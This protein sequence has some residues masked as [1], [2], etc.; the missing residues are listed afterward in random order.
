MNKALLIF[1]T[2]LLLFSISGIVTADPKIHEKV[3]VNVESNFNNL[4]IPDAYIKFKNAG[5]IWHRGIVKKTDG[6]GQAIFSNGGDGIFDY[7][8][9]NSYSTKAECFLTRYCQW[10]DSSCSHVSSSAISYPT[11]DIN[12]P[13]KLVLRYKDIVVVQRVYP[14]TPITVPGE[15]EETIK[16]DAGRVHYCIKVNDNDGFSVEDADVRLRFKN[17]G[18]MI[19]IGGSIRSAGAKIVFYDGRDTPGVNGEWLSDF[20]GHW[21]FKGT[22]S[23]YGKPKGHTFAAYWYPFKTD[24]NGMLDVAVDI[25]YCIKHRYDNTIHGPNILHPLD[26]F[27]GE[28]KPLECF[29]EAEAQVVRINDG[30]GVDIL[31]N[32]KKLSHLNDCSSGY[33]TFTI[34]DECSKEYVYDITGG[35]DH[36]NE[37]HAEFIESDLGCVRLYDWPALGLN[38]KMTADLIYTCPSGE[39][40]EIES[41]EFGPTTYQWYLNTNC[42]TGFVL[43]NVR[44]DIGFDRFKL[45][46]KVTG[47]VNYNLNKEF[48]V[49]PGKNKRNYLY[50]RIST[51]ICDDLCVNGLAESGFA[52]FSTGLSSVWNCKESVYDISKKGGGEPLGEVAYNNAIEKLKSIARDSQYEDARKSCTIETH[53]SS[54]EEVGQPN[55]RIIRMKSIPKVQGHS[56]ME[57]FSII[58]AVLFRKLVQI[59]NAM[60]GFTNPIPDIFI[61]IGR[62]I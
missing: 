19:N 8:D 21:Y 29:R 44:N 22:R 7:P 32:F 42:N 47:G 36:T 48:T 10:A 12:F 14:E 23:R 58:R 33:T 59:L 30:G 57:D 28:F 20:A 55:I 49:L 16:I 3:T 5:D 62:D 6:N 24:E 2:F 52:S 41:F 11:W 43:T 46:A 17:G 38:E 60:V 27:R 25:P 34:T 39:E 50:W 18:I 15:Y 56:S 61:S 35:G 51:G 31:T 40:I 4:P 45:R 26:R 1:T 53:I 13:P 9:C 54:R 37:I